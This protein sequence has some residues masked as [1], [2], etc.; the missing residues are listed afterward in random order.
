MPAVDAPTHVRN[1]W[2]SPEFREAGV[3]YRIANRFQPLDQLGFA[4]GGISGGWRRYVLCRVC[5][6]AKREALDCVHVYFS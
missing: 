2:Q 6:L 3:G 1:L 4:V 5:D